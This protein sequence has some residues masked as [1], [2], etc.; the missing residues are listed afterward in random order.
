MGIVSEGTFARRTWHPNQYSGHLN[1]CFTPKHYSL[2]ESTNPEH[3]CHKVASGPHVMRDI[4]HWKRIM[5]SKM[6]TNK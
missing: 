6:G 3:E 1:Q 5:L 4:V 2:V